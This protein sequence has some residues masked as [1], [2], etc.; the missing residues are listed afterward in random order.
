MIADEICRYLAETCGHPVDLTSKFSDLSM[1]SLD[2]IEAMFNLEDKY[3]I[4]I[5]FKANKPEVETVG[6]LVTL[7]NEAENG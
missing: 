2:L 6:D 4:E 5:K 1:S 3:G 7:I